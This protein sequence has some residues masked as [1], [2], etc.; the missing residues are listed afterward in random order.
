LERGLRG[1]FGLD[2]FRF[3]PSITRGFARNFAE[4]AFGN[5]SGAIYTP[6]DAF[7]TWNIFQS[8]SVMLGKS[9]L[10]DFYFSY[11]GRVVQGF[12]TNGVREGLAFNHQ[13]GLEYRIGP[14]LLME[15]QY[16]YQRDRTLYGREDARVWFRHYF[17]LW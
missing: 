12:Q 17:D 7:N 8:S 15:V 10:S 9:F 6:M 1:F 3:R 4:S 2:E 11:S 13:V 14:G 5:A 16:D